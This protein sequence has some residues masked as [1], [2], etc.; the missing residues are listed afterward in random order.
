MLKRLPTKALTE[1]NV[2][3]PDRSIFWQGYYNDI[4]IWLL[5]GFA[6]PT[7]IWNWWRHIGVPCNNVVVFIQNIQNC[8]LL[9]FDIGPQK[10]IIVLRWNN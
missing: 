4:K 9:G 5:Q 8:E 10:G 2:S 3:R 1:E 7:G 6:H